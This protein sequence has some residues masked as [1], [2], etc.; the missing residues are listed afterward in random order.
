[1]N[2]KSLRL[3]RDFVYHATK[4]VLI[5]DFGSDST[6]IRNPGQPVL[7]YNLSASLNPSF[8]GSYSLI[9]DFYA[10]EIAVE[11]LILL[12]LEVTL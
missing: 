7:L 9:F 8:S 2:R 6:A 12:F 1:M 5:T 10:N 3:L 11:V 4:G